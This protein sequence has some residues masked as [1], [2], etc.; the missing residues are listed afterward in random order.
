[1]M[2]TLLVVVMFLDIQLVVGYNKQ[3]H[4]RG[5]TR[6]TAENWAS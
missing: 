5:V 6:S 3:D 2:N 4:C 1:M